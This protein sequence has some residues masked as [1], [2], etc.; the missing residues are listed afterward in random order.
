MISWKS[1]GLNW[2]TLQNLQYTTKRGNHLVGEIG[3]KM[4]MNLSLKIFFYLNVITFFTIKM[5]VMS[6]ALLETIKKQGEN[7][8]SL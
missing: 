2:S 6:L 4:E 5:M 7:L 1:Y 3:K 8:P